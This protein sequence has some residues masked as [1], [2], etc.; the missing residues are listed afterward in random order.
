MR[1]PIHKAEAA[2]DALAKLSAHL[3]ALLHLADEAHEII[4][5]NGLIPDAAGCLPDLLAD[6]IGAVDA[7]QGGLSAEIGLRAAA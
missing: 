6:L 1:Y 5:D 2:Y 4:S 7:Q 3:T